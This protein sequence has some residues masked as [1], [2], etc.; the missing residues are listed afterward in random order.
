MR[1]ITASAALALAAESVTL[2]LLV[3]MLL[4]VPVRMSSAPITINFGGADYLG[5]GNLGSVEAVDDSPGEYKNLVFSLNGVASDLLSVALNE[6]IRGRAV[7]VRLATVNQTT[8]VVLDAPLIWSGAL[9][10]MPIQMG[11]D[12]GAINVTAEHRGVTFGRPKP[13]NYTE[14]DQHRLYPG[15]T[16]LKTIQSQ[17]T[18]PDV[19]PKASFWAR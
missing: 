19:W 11:K 9:D 5:L 15:D 17:S 14:A 4:D 3:E 8:G 12:M 10:Q 6:S 7:Y 1:T 18:H 13:L 2:V 16:S